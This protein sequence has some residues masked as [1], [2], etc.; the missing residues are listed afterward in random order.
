MCGQII[1]PNRI[2]AGKNYTLSDY[3]RE[4]LS[5]QWKI[6]KIKMSHTE[7]LIFQFSP[8]NG[9]VHT[10][11]RFKLSYS[12]SPAPTRELTKCYKA[13]F[14]IALWIFQHLSR[15]KEAELEEVRAW[16]E[17]GDR[18]NLFRKPHLTCPWVYNR[19]VKIHDELC[20]SSSSKDDRL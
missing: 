13:L 16:L 9:S 15:M 6:R 1:R 19:T 2:G 18:H 7:S 20:P 17:F 14:Y 12:S 11:H 3:S 4:C 10:V 5:H 8:P